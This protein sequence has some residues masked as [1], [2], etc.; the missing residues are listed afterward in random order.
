MLVVVGGHSRNIG[1]TGVVA[2]LIRRTRGMKWTALKITQYGNAVC[3][4]HTV[5]STC[6]CEPGNG[7][8]FALEEP[9]APE[10]AIPALED[11]LAQARTNRAEIAVAQDRLE[12]RPRRSPGV[13]REG[14][15]GTR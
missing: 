4:R 8:E 14:H 7:E 9:L 12:P 1:K 5:E 15:A 11:A 6:G 2:G 13:L 10:R 3:S